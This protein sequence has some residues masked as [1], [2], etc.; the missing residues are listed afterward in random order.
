M[1]PNTME[2][3]LERWFARFD[4][5]RNGF[6]TWFSIALRMFRGAYLVSEKRGLHEKLGKQVF[7]R[8]ADRVADDIEL[9]A[10][11]KQLDRT[12]KKLELEE[13]LIRNLRFGYSRRSESSSS[14]SPAPS[15]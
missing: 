12:N 15:E 11:V 1:K 2:T 13:R 3:S 4:G 14:Q 5:V 7:E 8:F 10:L 6:Y 9:G